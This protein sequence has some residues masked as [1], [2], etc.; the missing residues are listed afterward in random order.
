MGNRQCVMDIECCYI[1]IGKSSCKY[2]VVASVMFL[3]NLH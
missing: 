1:E 3:F 2:D